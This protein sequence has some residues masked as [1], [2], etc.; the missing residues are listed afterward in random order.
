MIHTLSE[1]GL[2]AEYPV[3]YQIGSNFMGRTYIV[4]IGDYLFESPAT[5][6][7]RY[8]WDLSPGYASMPLIALSNTPR[9]M[10]RMLVLPYGPVYRPAHRKSCVCSMVATLF[11]CRYS[12]GSHTCKLISPATFALTSNPATLAARARDS[13]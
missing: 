9:A 2:T 1:R 11:R 4:Q 12:C 3:R 8:G 5:W 10:R 13:V 7:N 6:F